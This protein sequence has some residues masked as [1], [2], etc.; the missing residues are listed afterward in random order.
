MRCVATCSTSAPHDARQETITRRVKS[1]VVSYSCHVMSCKN[2]NCILDVGGSARI[3]TPTSHFRARPGRSRTARRTMHNIYIY[4]YI[5]MYTYVC[6]YIYTYIYI[7][8][9]ICMYVCIY[10]YIH[11][12]IQTHIY[13]YIHIHT[14]VG[15]HVYMYMYICICMCIY[16][17]I[18]ICIHIH[19]PDTG[20][21]MALAER[22]GARHSFLPCDISG[23]DLL[24][25]ASFV[26]VHKHYL[27]LFI[28]FCLSF[29]I[30]YDYIS[31]YLF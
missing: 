18:Y 15:I 22:D 27:L 20:R 6:I 2:L 28:L 5:C 9:Y 19:N 26:H 12:Y 3:R 31:C 13:I 4:I 7:Y 29:V 10:T 23:C 8:I 14:Y 16:I 11:I 17:Y 25:V 21:H 1:R 30:V 24:F